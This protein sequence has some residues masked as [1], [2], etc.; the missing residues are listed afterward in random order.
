M[1]NIGLLANTSSSPA[2]IPSIHYNQCS[3]PT[4]VTQPETLSN[5]YCLM[6]PFLYGFLLYSWVYSIL[7]RL[8]VHRYD[9]KHGIPSE[10]SIEEKI[11]KGLDSVVKLYW[12]IVNSRY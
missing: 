8:S 11:M 7:I 2:V 4:H 6:I 5:Y 1:T 3:E 9:I 10:W 12:N